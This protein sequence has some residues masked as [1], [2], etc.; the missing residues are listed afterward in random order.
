MQI[1]TNKM[2]RIPL[3]SIAAGLILNL[4]DHFITLPMYREFLEDFIPIHLDLEPE[5]HLQMHNEF[6]ARMALILFVVAIVLFLI[7]AIFCLRDMTKKE[8]AKSAAILVIYEIIRRALENIFISIGFFAGFRVVF[9][10]IAFMPMRLYGAISS[11]GFIMSMNF[12]FFDL[13][14]SLSRWPHQVFNIGNLIWL[15]IPFIFVLFGK[16]NQYNYYNRYHNRYN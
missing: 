9:N 16:R 3:L 2:L 7:I 13:Y 5:V 12:D 14:I 10:T 8:I 6:Q 15:A 4:V 11:I 1:L